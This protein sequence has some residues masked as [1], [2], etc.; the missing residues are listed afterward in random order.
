MALNN[1]RKTT[2]KKAFGLGGKKRKSL[3]GK[4]PT[5]KAKDRVSHVNYQDKKSKNPKATRSQQYSK[6]PRSFS[7]REKRPA[8]DFILGRNPVLE[9]LQENVDAAILRI[10]NGVDVDDRLRTIL[11]LASDKNIPVMEV[12]RKE[13][14]R[15]TNNTNH[16]GVALAV[17]AYKYKDLKEVLAHEKQTPLVVILDG[18]TDPRNLG[19][20]IRSAAGFFASAVVIAERRSAGVTGAVWKTASGALAHVPV[21]QV[22]NITR[23]ITE[24]QD[25]GF[26]AIAL[27]GEGEQNLDQVD[28]DLANNPL[29]LVIGAEGK[30][31]SRLVSETCDIRVKIPMSKKIESLNAAVATGV[32]LYSITRSRKLI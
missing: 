17:S 26:F 11:T 9:S 8:S 10:A 1:K 24:L 5:P 30:G 14:D 2:S 22:V 15:L 6:E 20:V 7:N 19:A 21:C 4:G 27:D 25:K 16:Q 32:A 29:V 12:D 31:V 13:L 3:K 28:P 23:T 18:V